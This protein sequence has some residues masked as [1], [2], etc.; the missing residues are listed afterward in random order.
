MNTSVEKELVTAGK[1]HRRRRQSPDDA[2]EDGAPATIEV[3]T[4]LYVNEANDLA[5]PDQLD[6]VERERVR[7]IAKMNLTQT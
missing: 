3:Y 2:A 6:S 4:G 7:L 1:S 5:R